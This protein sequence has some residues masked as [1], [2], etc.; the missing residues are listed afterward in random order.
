MPLGPMETIV[1]TFDPHRIAGA[2]RRLLVGSLTGR[3]DVVRRRVAVRATRPEC[4][5]PFRAGLL[6]QRAALSDAFRH[7]SGP[8]AID[9]V[10]E[11]KHVCSVRRLETTGQNGNGRSDKVEAAVKD[12]RQEIR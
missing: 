5:L 7:A 4:Q 10:P 11:D 1:T 3:S 8:R 12:R 9:H 6:R 2:G